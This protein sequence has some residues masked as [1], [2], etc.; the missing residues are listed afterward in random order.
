MKK[1][2]PLL[3]LCLFFANIS[4]AQQRIEY[5]NFIQTDTA[6]KW[7]AVYNSYVNLTPANPNFNIRNFYVNKLKKQGANAYIEDTAAF[8]VTSTSINYND[9]KSSI[10]KVDHDESKMNWYF[11]YDNKPNAYQATFDKDV[12]LCDTC[13]LKNRI[14]LFKIKQLLY[15][16]NYRLQVRNIML[17]PVI[18]KKPDAASKENTEYFETTNFAFY[19]PQNDDGNIPATAKFIARTCNTLTLLPTTVNNASGNNILTL[20]NWSLSSQLYKDVKQQKIKAYDT[21]K[22]IYPNLKNT[23]DYRKIEGYKGDSVMVVTYNDTAEVHDP[24]YQQY[25]VAINFDSLYSYT[26]IQDF[27]FDFSKEK[28]HSKLIAFAL[29]KPVVTSQGIFLG[30]TD[31]WGVIFPEEKKKSTKSSKKNK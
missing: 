11:N 12:N 31:Y 6:I 27:Y 22:S 19:D 10:K 29:R 21:E 17:S 13:V 7:A 14:S 18:Y 9:Y 25:P 24:Q 26:L 23:L 2:I 3:L 15:Y 8:A 30:Y 20:N 16:K 5:A 1:L 28:L 4:I